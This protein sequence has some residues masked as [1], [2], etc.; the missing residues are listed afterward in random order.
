M[1]TE[2]IQLEPDEYIIIYVRKHWFLLFLSIFGIVAAALF[3]P[4]AYAML[5]SVPLPLNLGTSM[6]WDIAG[7]LYAVWLLMLWMALFKIWT[8]YYLDVWTITNRRLIAIDQRGLFN[9][10]ISSFRLER[11]QDITVEITGII[12]TFLDYGALRAQTAGADGKE[13][14]AAGLPHPRE[15]KATIL[16]AADATTFGVPDANIKP[17]LDTS[18]L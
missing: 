17:S 6:N 10:R 18:A 12:A 15:L 9:R 3:P 7:G 4:I 14:V 11:L 2:K 8:N 16:S 13:F 5:S 1:L